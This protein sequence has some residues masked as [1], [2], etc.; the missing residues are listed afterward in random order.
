MGQYKASEAGYNRTKP[1]YRSCHFGKKPDKTKSWQISKHEKKDT[2]PAP[3]DYDAAASIRNTR[4]KVPNTPKQTSERI[5]FI[6]QTHRSKG[7]VPGIGHYK[8]C[9]SITSRPMPLT[10]TLR[11]SNNLP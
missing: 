2:G 10:Q 11:S 6:T 8:P 3:G 5:S 4:W 7:W 9:D 1:K